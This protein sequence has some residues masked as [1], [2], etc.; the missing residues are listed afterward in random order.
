MRSSLVPH[1]FSHSPL[2]IWPPF[3]FTV[4]VSQL[5]AIPVVSQLCAIPVV[6]P[7]SQLCAV[8]VV[9]LFRVTILRYSFWFTGEESNSNSVQVITQG[10]YHIFTNNCLDGMRSVI[11]LAHANSIASHFLLQNSIFRNPPKKDNWTLVRYHPCLELRHIF[12]S[13]T[14]LQYGNAMYSHNIQA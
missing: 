3:S 14:F 5:C 1:Q 6:S 8:P 12:S 10:S 11:L 2:F 4:S 9:S 13:E 7:V